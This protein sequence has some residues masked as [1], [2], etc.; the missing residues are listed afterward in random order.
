MRP[1]PSGGVGTGREGELRCVYFKS[2][3]LLGP[4]TCAPLSFP[5]R[6][7]IAAEGGFGDGCA[8]EAER[9]SSHFPPWWLQALPA[10]RRLRYRVKT[11]PVPA[12]PTAHLE[13][14][15]PLFLT[16]SVFY[17]RFLLS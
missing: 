16:C 17:F 8:G 1:C 3:E 9:P 4:G 7:A 13:G 12:T 11:Y 2:K 5:A 15:L 10:L 6:G 14:R